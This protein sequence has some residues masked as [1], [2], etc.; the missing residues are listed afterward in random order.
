MTLLKEHS[1]LYTDFYELRMAQGYFMNNR[2]DDRVTFDYFFRSNPFEGG[3]VVFAGLSTLLTILKKLSYNEEDCLY[4]ESIGFDKRFTEYLKHFRFTGDIYAPEEG[5]IVFPYETIIRV[6]GN[7]IEAQIIETLL[8]NII[9][10]ESLIATKASRMR[11]AAGDRMLVDFGLRRAQGLGG[12]QAS[13]AAIIGGFDSTSNVLTAF[14]LHLKS[15]G[16]MAHSWVQS[17]NNELDA[18]REFAR[19]YPEN[20][21]L[22]VDTYNTLKS[23]IPNAITVAKEM[24]KNNTQLKGI[25]LDSGDLAFLSKAARK[26]LDEANLNYVKIVVSNRLDEFIIT[27]LLKEK[28]PIDV[29]GVGTSLVTGKGDGALDGVYKLTSI[30]NEPTLKKSENIRKVTLPGPK[31][32]YRFIDEKNFF[33]MDGITLENDDDTEVLYHPFE[34]EKKT[35]TNGLKKEKLLEKRMG[36]G[37]ILHRLKEPEEINL[38]VQQRLNQLAEEHKRFINPHIYRVGISQKLFDLKQHLLMKNEAL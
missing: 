36:E 11:M 5:E 30:N 37:K 1:G 14:I 9:N 20:C 29:F 17:F 6:E 28:A 38:F 31:N 21:I 25:R 27:S 3:Y 12:I 26:M 23:G 2:T 15:S 7:I 22:L 8:L 24:E 19:L 16:T 34:P 32:I 33:Y 18:F 35:I 13:K 4:L 10:F